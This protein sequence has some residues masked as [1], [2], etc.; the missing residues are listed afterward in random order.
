MPP[1]LDAFFRR[2]FSP[3]VG[4][5][6]QSA[7]ELAQAFARAAASG[8]DRHAATDPPR[9]VPTPSV[10][11]VTEAIPEPPKTRWSRASGRRHRPRGRSS[12]SEL[13][14]GW[15]VLAGSPPEAAAESRRPESTHTATIAA[16]PPASS[17]SPLPSAALELPPVSFSSLPRVDPRAAGRPP[18]GRGR[19]RLPRRRLRPRRPRPHRNPPEEGRQERGLLGDL[20]YPDRVSYDERLGDVPQS[21][22]FRG[23]RGGARV[24][25][26]A[27]AGVRRPRVRREG[28]LHARAR[29]PDAR[30]LRDRRRAVPEGRRALPRRPR[31]P[32]QPRRVR[33]VPR[34]LRVVAPGLARPDARAAHVPGPQVRGLGQ[35]RRPL[36][37]R[38]SRRSSRRSRST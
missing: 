14:V 13:A 18:P 21:P 7:T 2:A 8:S 29:A 37:P 28:P 35:G 19:A 5:R 16:A 20:D 15:R 11:T 12:S 26:G 9:G 6:F 3:A 36:R 23:D 25:P 27:A 1:A 31:Q 22:P 33:G 38:G 10:V 30:G 4:A 32:A 34:P 17:A 24:L